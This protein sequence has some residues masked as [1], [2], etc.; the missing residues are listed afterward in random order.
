[1]AGTSSATLAFEDRFKPGG[2]RPWVMDALDVRILRQM[3]LLPYGSQP[4]DPSVFKPTVIARRLDTT[5]DTVKA[6]IEGMEEDGVLLGYQVF[7]NLDHLDLRSGAYLADVEETDR[8]EAVV[9]ALAELD[10]VLVLHEYLDDAVCV[11][12]AFRDEAEREATLEAIRERTGDPE[13]RRFYD[14]VMPDV[15]RELTNLDWRIL[16]SLRG[17]ATKPLREVAAD[18]GVTRKTVKRRYDRMAAEG[19]FVTVPLLDPSQAPGLI[20]FE[21]MFF[22]EPDTEREVANDVL[23]AYEEHRVFH[24][25]PATERLG[26]FNI[27]CFA[28]TPARIEELRTQGEALAGVDRVEAGLFSR[29]V[30]RQGWLDDE[31]EAR[32]EATAP[33]SG[34]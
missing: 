12:Y 21:L 6:R 11:E 15:D 9:D 23:D 18:V 8:T 26:N 1:M 19:S 10:R 14:G 29:F 7:P 13:P 22:A 32:I 24:Y 2:L 28:K 4:R 5:R 33:T 17:E 16:A 34:G 25:V 27:L 30:D 31:I 3:D 20:L